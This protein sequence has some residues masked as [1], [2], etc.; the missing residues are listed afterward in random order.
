MDPALKVALLTCLNLMIRVLE[1][2]ADLAFGW[3]FSKGSR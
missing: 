3:T 2:F 1:F